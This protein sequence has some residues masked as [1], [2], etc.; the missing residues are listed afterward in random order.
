MKKI[1]FFILGLLAT[2]G[3]QVFSQSAQRIVSLAPSLTNMLY[4]LN[5]GDRIVGCTSYC[6]E[7][8]KENKEI[9][10]SAIEVNVEKVLVLKPDW[11]V[12]TTI[13]KPNTI[14]TLKTMGINVLVLSTPKSYNDI[15]N[16]L[17][18]LAKPIGKEFMAQAI[19]TKQQER[20]KELAQKVPS[21]QKPKV[22]F[23][24]GAQPLFTVIPN[25]FM[26][27]YIT[28]FGGI[29]IASGL[30]RGTI[31]RENVLLKDPDVIVV[32]TMGVVG[33]EEK[34]TWA[35][36]PNLSA[37]KTGKIFIIGSDKACSPNPVTFV[38]VVEQLIKLMYQ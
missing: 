17:L 30:T 2:V 9:V 4:L 6:K 24:I 21:G 25:T 31:T 7:A 11:V 14:E 26:D 13:T 27:D 16:Q 10:A 1:R 32:V 37:A 15:C 8:V 38:D 18:T 36:Y 5:A 33:E 23:E 34:E 3:F 20:L 19:I 29:N 35:A 22:F 12:A 28:F